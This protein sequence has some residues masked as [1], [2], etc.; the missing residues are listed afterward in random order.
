MHVVLTN[1]TCYLGEVKL[2]L[3]F[4]VVGTIKNGLCFE[5]IKTKSSIIHVESDIDINCCPS[6]R[7]S[8]CISNFKFFNSKR[9]SCI[10]NT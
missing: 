1:C 4:K 2:Y 8:A 10:S 6:S 9:F 5:K 7:V 3:H